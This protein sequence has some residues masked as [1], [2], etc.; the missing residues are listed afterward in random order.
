MNATPLDMG[1]APDEHG[2]EVRIVRLEVT[3]D[4]VVTVLGALQRSVDA[5]RS[6]FTHALEAQ[7]VHF[8]QALGEQR[9]YITQALREQR[10][11]FRQEL[12]QHREDFGVGLRDQ[13]TDL[14]QA[15][16]KQTERIDALIY[17]MARERRW[18]IAY[19]MANSGLLLGVLLRNHL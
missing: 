9:E 11:E 16:S 1:S 15:I 19:I 4:N 5:M 18:I 17:E 10:N 2:H 3:M 14:Q 13:R 8:D 6:E 7:R 12:Q